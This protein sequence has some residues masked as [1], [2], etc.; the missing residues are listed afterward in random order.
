MASLDRAYGLKGAAIALGT[1]AVA[2]LVHGVLASALDS[3]LLKVPLLL[4]SIIVLVIAGTVSARRSLATAALIAVAMALIFFWMRWF[5]WSAMADAARFVT[6]P[7][8]RWPAYLAAGGVT[9]LWIAEF[10]ATLSAA[11]F[12][13]MAG[14]ERSG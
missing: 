12:G 6:E 13:C 1:A 3:I 2:G 7:P 9:G 8:W 10:T 4:V 14:H 11:I 5:G